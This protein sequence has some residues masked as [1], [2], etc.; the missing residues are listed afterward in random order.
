[1]LCSQQREKQQLPVKMTRGIPMGSTASGTQRWSV[2]VMRQSGRRWRRT[3]ESG[4]RRD[5]VSVKGE[6][7]VP[8][9][10]RGSEEERGRVWRRMSRPDA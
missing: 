3:S 9:E 5:E 4:R 10:E 1:M 8:A 2:S 6:A 7:D